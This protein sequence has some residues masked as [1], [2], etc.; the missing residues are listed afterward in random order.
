MIDMSS[1]MD[2]MDSMKSFDIPSSSKSTQSTNSSVRLRPDNTDDDLKSMNAHILPTKSSILKQREKEEM[3]MK[4]SDSRQITT[5]RPKKKNKKKIVQSKFHGDAPVNLMTEFLSLVSS[6]QM[7]AALA[8][9]PNIL[10]YEP[11]NILIKMYQETMEESIRIAAQAKAENN[12]ESSSS[13]SESDHENESDTDTSAGES[14]YDP[15]DRYNESRLEAKVDNDAKSEAKYSAV[16]D[17][18][19]DDKNNYK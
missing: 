8:L 7:E 19:R 3:S 2:E 14:D 1:L 17:S 16:S 12:G 18:C 6:N 5:Q 4:V 9:C 13:E 15:D 10:K 11:D